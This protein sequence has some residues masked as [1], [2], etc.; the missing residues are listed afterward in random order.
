M[1]FIPQS[2]IDDLVERSD[3]VDVID[4]RVKL[5]KSG[6]DYSACCPFHDEKTPSFTVSQDKQF[7]HCFGCG[8]NGNII[9]FLMD[10]ERLSF[11]EAVETLARLAGVEVPQGHSDEQRDQQKAREKKRQS[12]YQVMESVNHYYQRQLR[13]HEQR[14]T[15]INYLKQRGLSGEIARQFGI[16]FAPPGYNNLTE[17]LAESDEKRSLLLEA[18][19]LIENEQHNCYDRFRQR[20]M[21]P[22]HDTRGRVIAFGGRILG[23]GKP[24]YLNSP[25][26]SLFQKNKALYGLYEA[27]QSRQQLSRLL[28]VEGYMDVVSLAQFDIHYAVATLG[29]ACGLPH[30]QLAF[31]FVSEI[32][33][34]FDGDQAGRQAARRAMENALPVME[35]GRQLKFLYLPEGEDP[36]T[37]IRQ[38]GAEKFTHLVEEAPPLEQV[39]FDELSRDLDTQTM[40]GRA[41]LCKLAAPLLNRLPRGVYRELCFNQLAQRTQLSM[42]RLV[43]LLSE[44]PDTDVSE[45]TP[46]KPIDHDD[47]PIIEEPPPITTAPSYQPQMSVHPPSSMTQETV[48]NP[49]NKAIALLLY[50]PTLAQVTIE[51]DEL[52]HNNSESVQLLLKLIALLKQ[53]PEFSSGQIL[54]HWQG[55]YG[56]EATAALKSLMKKAASYRKAESSAK[57]THEP[58][59]PAKEFGDALQHLKKQLQKEHCDSIIQRL[60]QKPLSEWSDDDKQRYRNATNQLNN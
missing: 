43:D 55:A 2:F 8:A 17:A 58:F 28:M 34:C 14:G 33:F 52:Q 46:A 13:K 5:K 19:M 51:I 35:D 24:K 59:D 44:L 7:F 27:R 37:L 10:Y 31:K 40:E 1:S 12:L 47:H 16:G 54:G 9:S 36:D 4:S 29:T 18:G 23:S 21:F 22:I 49:A 3:I 41:R 20:I 60:K 57:D 15:A 11:P 39:L 38:I 30:L 53:R 32:V 45:T 25:E 26:T 6:K 56:A 48:L 50:R 42:D